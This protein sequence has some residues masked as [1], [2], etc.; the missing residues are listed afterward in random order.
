MER[1]DS[2]LVFPQVNSPA[3]LLP[4]KTDVHDIFDDRQFVILPKVAGAGGDG[5]G[6]GTGVGAGAGAE[7]G[8]GTGTGNIALPP[9]PFV[10]HILST[11]S[12]EFWPKHHNILVQSLHHRAGPYLLARFAWAV[13]IQVKR[14]IL[15][16]PGRTV[17]LRK[18]LGDDVTTYQAKV[19]TG[20]ELMKKFGGGGSQSATPVRDKR[21]ASA[22]DE[23]DSV[24]SSEDQDMWDV[25]DDQDGKGKRQREQLSSEETA[26]SQPS[27][28]VADLRETLLQSMAEQQVSSEA[29]KT[30][31]AEDVPEGQEDSH[32]VMV[33]LRLK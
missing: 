18:T 17:I 16:G 26:P 6:A 8:T 13:L 7:G 27:D 28:I 12:A 1:Y 22:M 20:R 9:L 29:E 32:E 30:Q 23:D 4:L 10:T 19:L 11:Q 25:M 24:G 31:E 5:A 33:A 21:P 15:S 3:N 14:F 2:T